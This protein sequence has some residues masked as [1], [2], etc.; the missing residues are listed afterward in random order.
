M[1]D[2]VISSNDA[3]LRQH[4][5][6]V[7]SAHYEVEREI[8]RGG[9][10]I[11]YL[12]RDVR[13][14]R[15]VAVKLLPPELAFRS[16]IRSRFLRE[17]ETAAQLSHPN[18][19]PIYTVDEREGLVYF[20]M[21]YIDGGNL[22]TRLAERG[23][24][25][26]EETRRIL[27]EVADA[28][29]YAHGRGVVHRDI[30]PDNILLCGDDDGRAVVT[31]FGIARAVSEGA[32]S[33]LTATG[34]AIGTPTY[35]SPEQAA[36]ERDIDGR[37][38][39]YSLGIVG[40]QMLTGVPPFSANSTPALLVKHLSEVPRPVSDRVGGVPDDLARAIM[41]MLE[42]DPD[43]R[44]PNAA[45][46]V[47]AL[48]ERT[49]PEGLDHAPPRAMAGGGTGAAALGSVAGAA[50]PPPPYLPA[51]SEPTPDEMQR[52]YHKP[53]VDFRK[54]VGPYLIVNAAIVL[55]SIFTGVDLV[56]FT[57]IWTV[58]MAYQYAKLWT[59]G[60][61]WRDVFKQSRDRMIFDVAAE[62][63]DDA[64]ALFDPK[65][66]D[67]VR[68]RERARR[69]RGTGVTGPFSPLP[70]AG[71]PAGVPPGGM[72]SAGLAPDGVLQGDYAVAVRRALA[73]RDEIVRLVGTL[74]KRDRER[75]GD[76]VGS[77]EALLGTIRGLAVSLGEAERN[78]APGAAAAIDAE[79]AQLEAQAN[80]L[81]RAA[82]EDRVRRLAYLKRQRR[83]LMDAEQR[84][85]RDELRLDTCVLALQN[86][87]LDLLRLKEGAQGH[88]QVTQLVER[89][90]SLAH[91]VDGMVAA[92]ELARVGTRNQ[93][94]GTRV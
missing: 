18:I 5:Q 48:E 24:V 47:T 66:R 58:Y 80:P 26:P 10:G 69:A 23:R 43:A 83:A 71:L 57:A 16:E 90:M 52:W 54:K 53:V 21:G 34:M 56:F 32:D 15:P 11:V 40:Y 59:D 4:V 22:A 84:R 33:R 61:D 89:A 68:A 86:L 67:E 72:S 91:D 82:S 28:L 88:Q 14:K 6:R 76:V 37:S 7:L 20:I 36:G 81:D 25:E 94:P 46:L 74:G 60:Y 35:M 64:K 31:D 63:I 78:A 19:V 30:K 73:D 65:K 42:K 13:L 92:D 41:L 29:A 62:T 93:A 79:I 2:P 87:R 3:E 39:L 17:A 50:P 27:R 51:V 77:A 9:M 85:Q 44:F 38:D 55:M 75:I 8:G 49:I 1:P 12:A 45:A 70:G